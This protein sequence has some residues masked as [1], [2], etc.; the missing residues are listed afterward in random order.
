MENRRTVQK[1]RKKIKDEVPIK[2]FR[3]EC[4]EFAKSW[5]DVHIKEF[6]RLGVVG[7]F[8]NYYSTMSYEAEAQIVRELGKFL[9]DGSLY[10]GFKPVLWSTVEKTA[11]ADAEVEYLDHTS[12]TIYVAFKVKETNKDFLKNTSIIIWTTTPWTIPAN[13]ALAFNSN[14]EYSVLEI[15]NLE[16]FKDKKIV[17]AKNLI[18][19]ITKECEIKSY[20]EIE[21]FKGTEFK[22]TLCSHPFAKMGFDYDVPMLDAQFVN[23][24]QGTGIVHCAPSH[25]PDDFNLCLNNNIPS[26]YTVDNSGVYTKEVPYFTNTHVF[27]ADPIVIDK[28]KEQKQLLKKR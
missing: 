8:E 13:K 18:D 4:R 3:Q 9:I 1:K 24:D 19:T 16:H 5:I 26:L 6:K 14:I 2:D 15:D 28:L 17:V 25:G 7:D 11:L 21:T 23:L 20:K 10:Q 22:G 12:N 27:K